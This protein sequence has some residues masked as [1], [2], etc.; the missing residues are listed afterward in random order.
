MANYLLFLIFVPLSIGL[1]VIRDV[2]WRNRFIT[3]FVVIWLA[4]FHYESVRHFYLEPLVKQSLPKMKFL[5]PPAG[6]IMF[7]N[8][9]DRFG[10]REVY[11][12]KEGKLQSIDPHE[13]VRT[14]TI[15]YD[16]IYRGVL[17]TVANPARAKDFCKYLNYRFPYFESFAVNL[18]YYPSITKEPYRRLQQVEYVCP[19]VSPEK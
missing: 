4:L 18:V 8:V 10:Y 6:W 13:I 5:F 3:V 14:R 1:N 17:G 19:Q 7:F 9:D 11:G 12:I 16:N 2:R 15:G